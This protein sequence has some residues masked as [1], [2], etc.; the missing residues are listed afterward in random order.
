MIPATQRTDNVA[1]Y[2]LDVTPWSTQTQFWIKM[3]AYTPLLKE[4]SVFE[5]Y[6]SIKDQW[7]TSE[8]L[9]DTVMCSTNYWSSLEESPVNSSF[10]V[11]DYQSGMLLFNASEVGTTETQLD[12]YRDTTQG[13][14]NDWYLSSFSGDNSVECNQAYCKVTCV[15]YRKLVTDDN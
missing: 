9:Y 2:A 8:D 10:S 11:E 5:M 6:T 4:N 13:G 1:G 14:S 3:E 15:V 12:S 7:N